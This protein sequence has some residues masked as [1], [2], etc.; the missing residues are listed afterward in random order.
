MSWRHTVDIYKAYPW[1]VETLDP[2]CSHHACGLGDALCSILLKM[3]QGIGDT[4]RVS[5]LWNRRNFCKTKCNKWLF[6][7]WKCI[8]FLSFKSKRIIKIVNLRTVEDTFEP[9]HDKPK[10]VSVRPTKTQIS[11]GI[12]PVWSVF[13]ACMKKVWVL[14]YPLSAQQRLWSDWADAQADMCLRWAHSPF[15]DFVMSR[16]I[17]VFIK[18]PSQSVYWSSRFIFGKWWTR[19][20]HNHNELLWNQS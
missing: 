13:A 2:T 14:S 15:V 19:H 16:L 17:F 9:R 12:H 8:I 3:W 1:S 18:I 6:S 5:G 7:M 11:L 20:L 4:W 10:K